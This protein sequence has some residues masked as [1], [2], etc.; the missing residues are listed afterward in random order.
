MNIP[1]GLKINKQASQNN[2]LACKLIK[3]LHGLKQA[4][5]MWFTKLYQVLKELGFKQ[6]KSVY[7]LFS[8]ING[9]NIFFI[10]AYVDDLLITGKRNLKLK[11]RINKKIQH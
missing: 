6:T 5:R 1:Q 8:K 10:L 2:K 3:S 9:T 7:I 4:Y 11:G